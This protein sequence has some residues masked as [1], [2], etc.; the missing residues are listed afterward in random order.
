MRFGRPLL[1]CVLVTFASTAA[2]SACGD[3]S[4][5]CRDEDC[6]L[7]A[8]CDEDT[9]ACVCENGGECASESGS[10]DASGGGGAGGGS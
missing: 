9:N 4:D 1:L 7:G 5:S 6:E 10:D 2:T 8:Y 3:D